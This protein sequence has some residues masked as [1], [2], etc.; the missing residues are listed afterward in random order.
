MY[1]A[2]TLGADNAVSRDRAICH[3]TV[4]RAAAQLH[5]QLLGSMSVARGSD[6]LIAQGQVVVR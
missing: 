2:A 1:I 4:H 3:Q 6:E 5:H